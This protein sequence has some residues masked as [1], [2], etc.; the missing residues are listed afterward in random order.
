M[1]NGSFEK[2][3]EKLYKI[4]QIENKALINDDSE[5]L[6]EIVAAKQEIAKELELYDVSELDVGNQE[7]KFLV[8]K[9]RDLQE[10][11]LVLTKQ[12]MNY[13]DTFISAFQKEA[14]KNITYSEKGKEKETGCSGL[15]NRSL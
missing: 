4:L 15:L 12:A 14:K 9:A 5:K 11:N 13:A 8:Q 3:L 10:T 7:I 2:N 1:M 6:E